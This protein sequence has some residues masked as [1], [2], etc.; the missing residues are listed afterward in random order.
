[1]VAKQFTTVLFCINLILFVFCSKSNKEVSTKSNNPDQLISVDGLSRID[2]D[3]SS[4]KSA[5]IDSIQQIEEDLKNNLPS[6]RPI[7]GGKIIKNY[8]EES[9]NQNYIS[10]KAVGNTDVLATA[11]GKVVKIIIDPSSKLKIITIDHF[12]Y[13][14]TVYSNLSS[15]KVQVGQTVNRWDILGTIGNSSKTFMN[16]EV[17]AKNKN[18]DPA[19]FIFN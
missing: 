14:T 11:N 7:L 16:Y 5:Q 13:I 3:I 2:K 9:E 6:I 1:M 10:I 15:V 12:K 19:L 8:Q 18:V 4:A 17:I